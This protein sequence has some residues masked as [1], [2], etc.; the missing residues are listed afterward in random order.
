M[1]EI[2]A[3]ANPNPTIAT[4]PRAVVKVARDDLVEEDHHQH[5][6]EGVHRGKEEECSGAN[7]SPVEG[8][9]VKPWKAKRRRKGVGKNSLVQSRLENFVKFY[10]NSSIRGCFVTNGESADNPG[11]GGSDGVQRG[12]KRRLVETEIRQLDN[13][14]FGENSAN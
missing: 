12:I 7:L 10:P 6:Q 3:D 5:H 9:K 11:E 2:S 13:N 4:Q 14:R 8:R 1:A